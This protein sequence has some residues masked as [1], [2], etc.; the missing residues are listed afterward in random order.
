MVNIRFVS[1]IL[2]WC[3]VAVFAL[4]CT[5]CEEFCEEMNRTA[6]VVNFF[7]INADLTVEPLNVTVTIIGIENES[8]LY[9][10][11]L[12]P[13]TF[14]QALLPINPMA[15]TMSFSFKNDT[16]PAD[17]IIF[18]YLR[19]TGF[20]SPECGCASFAEIQGEPE[21]TG[22]T[23]INL[24]VTNPSVGVVSYRQGVRNAENIRIYY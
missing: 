20:I 1:K 21:R 12:F 2:T 7:T 18:R 5:S 16:L 11:D 3:G 17:T 23:I 15:D 13:R 4:I 10:N 8:T 9:P 24:V 14:S 6:I 19:H 22:N